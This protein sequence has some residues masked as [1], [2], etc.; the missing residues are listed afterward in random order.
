MRLGY[1]V[2]SSRSVAWLGTSACQ[3]LSIMF[4]SVGWTS[5]DVERVTNAWSIVCT[6]SESRPCQTRVEKIRLTSEATSGSVPFLAHWFDSPRPSFFVSLSLSSSSSSSQ[7]VYPFSF[8]SS[9]PSPNHTQT[10]R[11]FEIVRNRLGPRRSGSS[12]S[13]AYT[14]SLSELSN[15]SLS[16]WSLT[17]GHFHPRTRTG[18]CPL[19]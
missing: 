5:E 11:I 8:R 9:F 13:H 15:M 17:P 10:P 1:R 14:T 12:L 2:A 16:H 4:V 7:P 6:L 3:K 19:A 18:I